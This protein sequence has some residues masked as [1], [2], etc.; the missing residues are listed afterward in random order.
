MAQ[1][2]ERVAVIGTRSHNFVV[3]EDGVVR[4]AR[5]LQRGGKIGADIH[6]LGFD[7]QCLLVNQNRFV[8]LF[9]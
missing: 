6:C 1:L 5:A 9:F 2:K 3:L 7:L 4:A 8:P